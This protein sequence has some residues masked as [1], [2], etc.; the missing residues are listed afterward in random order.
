MV[1]RSALVTGIYVASKAN[2]Q[3]MN[4]FI[5]EHEIRPVI[6]KVFSFEDAALAYDHMLNSSFMG[7]I[8]ISM[9]AD[10]SAE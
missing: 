1:R 7:K 6:D 10:A 3:A 5:T 2:F 9:R 4:L 8:V